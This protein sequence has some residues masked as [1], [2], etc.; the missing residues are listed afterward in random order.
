MCGIV[1]KESHLLIV[2]LPLIHNI[3]NIIQ[4]C[5]IFVEIMKISRKFWESFM[6]ILRNFCEN[7]NK[8]FEIWRKV[9]RNFKNIMLEKIL[10]R[11]FVKI[12]R[13]FCRNYE[14]FM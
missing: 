14:N 13:Y 10:Q 5:V 2:P 6:E 1:T 9:C 8:F 11:K 7:Y 3:Y 4:N 12:L